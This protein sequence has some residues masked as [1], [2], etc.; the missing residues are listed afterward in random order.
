MDGKQILRDVQFDNDFGLSPIGLGLLL[1][2]AGL[3]GLGTV[4]LS[5]LALP[6]GGTFG[7][8]LAIAIVYMG[9]NDCK[10][11]SRRGTDTPALQA[12]SELQ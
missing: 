11:I 3:V 9:A 4:I 6:V 10:A 2:D 5:V 1:K 12:L 8:P 7:I